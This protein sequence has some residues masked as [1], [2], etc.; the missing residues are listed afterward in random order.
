MKL[1]IDGGNPVRDTLL[2]YGH[3]W[4]DKED[5]EAV[6]DALGSD[7]I[8]QG[9]KVE[10]FEKKIAE[11]CGVKYAVAVCNGTAALHLACKVAGV[12]K[13]DDVI[14][15]PLTFAATA[16]AIVYCQ[17]NPIFADIKEDTLNID[18]ADVENFISNRSKALISVDFA[19]NPVDY[20]E[21]R[22]ICRKNKMVFI[23]DSCHALG[24]EY[25]GKKIG[26]LADMTVFSFHPVKGI[27]TGEG[28][29]I[30]T[31]NEEYCCQL[32]LY[33]HH[34]IEKNILKGGWY[35][36][37]FDIGYNYRLTDFQSALGISQLKKLDDNIIRRRYIASLYR[38]AF[39]DIPEIIMQKENGGHAYHIFPVQFDLKKFKVDRLRIYNALR[40]ENIGVNVHYMPLHL[41]PFYKE[42]Y[43]YE[44]GD[45]PVSER[46]YDRAITLPLWAR[47]TKLDALN[48]I[49]AVNKVV[50]SY[51][52]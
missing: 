43:Y 50:E 17:G 48:V 8:T 46:Y 29:M 51:K 15:T 9:P 41:Q 5:K 13:K 3:Q 19:G 42:K 38:E 7:Y 16:N 14:T 31:D 40:A 2:P 28:A 39:K 32:K 18:P 49:E 11:Y 45:Y 35:Y 24:G 33:R 1:A 47:M 22:E 27:T 12:Q 52:I 26:S 44:K 34:G 10:E 4:I 20:D 36:E 21:L 6:Y 37:I 23:S 30:L 25:K